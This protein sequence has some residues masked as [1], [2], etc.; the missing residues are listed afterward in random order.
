MIQ[1]KNPKA[2]MSLGFKVEKK[3]FFIG[4]FY[5]FDKVYQN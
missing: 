2:N 4:L 3:L 5:P 1:E